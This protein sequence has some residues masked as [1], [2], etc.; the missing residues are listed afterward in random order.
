M[1]E[2]PFQK[3]RIRPCMLLNQCNHGPIRRWGQGLRTLPLVKSQV[4]KGFLR[5]SGMD[6]LE[7]QLDPLGPIASR[8]RSVRPSV[9]YFDKR[10]ENSS[11]SGPTLA[12]FS[13]SAHRF[14]EALCRDNST[15]L[16]FIRHTVV[17]VRTHMAYETNRKYMQQ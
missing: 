16:N 4:A 11:L 7:R 12:E 13:R 8:R 15:E 2:P 3:S 10:K 14:T 9:K 17:S 5:N 1:Y 6:P